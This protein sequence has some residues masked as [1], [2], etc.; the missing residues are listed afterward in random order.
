MPKPEDGQEIAAHGVKEA[1]CVLCGQW[2]N[3]AND[4]GFG[5]GQMM[6]THRS[7]KHRTE[8]QIRASSRKM[9]VVRQALGSAS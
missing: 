3:V 7:Q 8:A 5:T 4:D 2:V 9:Q 1:F 6:N